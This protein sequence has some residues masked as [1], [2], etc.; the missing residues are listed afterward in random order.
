MEYTVDLKPDSLNAIESTARQIAAIVH[1]TFN[2]DT[3]RAI[4]FYWNGGG[5]STY[6]VLYDNKDGWD[7][8][9]PERD[10][11]RKETDTIEELVIYTIAYIFSVNIDK[12]GK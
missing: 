11:I 6:Y 2:A 8:K 9:Y 1:K 5:S 7:K 3:K 4:F 10:S 12:S